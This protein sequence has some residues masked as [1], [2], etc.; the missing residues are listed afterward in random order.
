LECGSY[1][2]NGSARGQFEAGEYVGLDWRPGP[3]VDVVGLAHE[4]ADEAGFDTVISTEMLEHYPFWPASLANMVRLT[5][6]GGSLI[7]TC[8]GP[9]R[10]AHE[11]ECAPDGAGSPGSYYRGLSAVEVVR[12][13]RR[14]GE[15]EH[16]HAE[17]HEAPSDTY[18][19]CWGLVA[20]R[21]LAEWESAEIVHAVSVVIP[22]VG[23]PTLTASAV[24]AARE[25]AGLPC[26]V[27]LVD[28]GSRPENAAAL[29]ELAG[30]DVYLRYDA[31]LGYPAACNRGIEVSAGEYVCLLNND[32]QPETPGWAAKLVK[33]LD[34]WPAAIVAPVT[35]FVANPPQLA[36]P[37]SD[38]KAPQHPFAVER[39]FF[40]CVLLRRELF[41]RVGLLDEE[42]GLGN[43]E[44]EEFCWRVRQAGGRLL[45]D[46]TVFV[47]HA[48]HATFGRLPKG[49]FEGLLAS[50]RA[51]L[52]RKISQRN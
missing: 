16:I 11:V 51:L 26:E 41:G 3:G 23:Q 9:R 14:A 32:A 17:Q 4:Y 31:M 7:V 39:L 47:H 34:G 24:R 13:L 2:I 50:N 40:V 37:A 52:A 8:A 21:D 12:Q 22:A 45:V 46:P 18:V 49:M 43:S 19:A 36:R 48:G 1:N 20:H 33:T 15:W 6:P 42:F 35:D 10:Q 27:V 5:K 28:N 38:R 29:A 25:H 44:D 30:V